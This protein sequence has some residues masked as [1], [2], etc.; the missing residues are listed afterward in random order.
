M[1]ERRRP[2]PVYLVKAG[3]SETLHMEDGELAK[4]SYAVSPAGVLRILSADPTELKWS[5]IKEY[6]PQG[7]TEVNGTRH[8]GD[9]VDKL[10]G[11]A[12]KAEHK[13]ATGR[14]Q[15]F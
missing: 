11:S 9:I 10:P 4:F 1:S 7:W 13:A 2:V 3:T 6:S 14:L 5:V 15:V 12:G 8:T